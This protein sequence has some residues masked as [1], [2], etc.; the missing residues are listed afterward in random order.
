M[1][2]RAISHKVRE[3]IRQEGLL[4]TLKRI[5]DSVHWRYVRYRYHTRFDRKYGVETSRVESEYLNAVQ[6][7]YVAASNFYEATKWREFARMMEAVPINYGEFIFVDAGCGKGRAL[8]F[9]SF[10]NFKKIIGVEFSEELVEIAKQNMATFSAKTGMRSALEIQCKDVALFDLPDGNLLIYLY[11]PFHSELMRLF[12]EKIRRFVERSAFQI[13]IAYRNP[14]CAEMFEEEP[15][16]ETLTHNQ[17]YSI[18]RAR[19]SA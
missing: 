3:L 5:L 14:V 17:E 1:T 8:M 19:R 18:Y 6:S 4:G 13:Y 15:I 7:D 16:L 11:N 9:A 2:V 10:F 12:I